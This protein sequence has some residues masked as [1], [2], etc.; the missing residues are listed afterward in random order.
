MLKFK[1]PF[2][3]IQEARDFAG[4]VHKE[5]EHN[6]DK[7]LTGY[8]TEADKKGFEVEFAHAVA[9]GSPVPKLFK[10]TKVDDYDCMMGVLD[11]T[12]S[13]YKK[14]KIMRFDI[15]TSEEFL[16]N[17]MQFDYKKIDAYLFE[18]IDYL[19]YS[20]DLIFLKVHGWIGKKEVPANS[21]LKRFPNGSEAYSVK[22]LRNP[23]EL[24]VIQ[25]LG[26]S[27]CT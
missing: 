18:S 8:E 20:Q 6:K 2:K 27:W 1:I 22:K 19:D 11:N 25:N 12:V 14:L 7:F 9:F 10:G 23:R 13:N 26:E 24:F 21:E 3:V 17:K 5:R 15:K 4:T 16:I